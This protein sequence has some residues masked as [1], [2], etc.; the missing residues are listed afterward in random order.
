MVNAREYN[1][2]FGEYIESFSGYEPGGYCPIDINDR[3]KDGRYQILIK[4]GYGGFAVVWGA[5][6]HTYA[7]PILNGLSNIFLVIIALYLL[8]S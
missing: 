8:R 6:D 2:G 7:T 1:L 5:Q 4:T 3:L